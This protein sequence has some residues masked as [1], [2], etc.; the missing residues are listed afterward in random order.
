MPAFLTDEV[1][2]TLKSAIAHAEKQTSGEIAVCL[3]KHVKGDIY[4]AAKKFFADKELYKTKDRNAVLI[5]LAYKDHKLAILG[6]EG[7]NEKVPEN[8]WA[9]TVEIMTS[10][11]KEGRYAKGLE[12]GILKIG[13]ELK[14]DFPWQEDDENEIANEIHV[15]H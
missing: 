4:D 14:D 12:E 9:S 10:N 8:F 11:F 13:Q 6:D 3:T 2:E 1:K 7:I 5:Y 15:E